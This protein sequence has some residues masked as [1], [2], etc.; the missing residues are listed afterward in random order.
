MHKHGLCCHAMSIRPSV[1]FVYSAKTSNRILLK[2]LSSSGSQS[3]LLFPHQ[4]S[5]QYS[6]GDLPGA[7]NAGWV[8]KNRYFRPVSPFIACC[9]RRDGQ[10]TQVLSTRCR[11][12]TASWWHSSLIAVSGG[13]CWWRE[14][15]DEVFT[16]R[17]STLHRRQQNSIWLYAVVNLKPK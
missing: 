4:T 16:T 7:S 2:L 10:V 12:T 8:R 11:R 14:T 15:D 3:I 17:T 6:D 1:T 5:W 13:V 9:Q